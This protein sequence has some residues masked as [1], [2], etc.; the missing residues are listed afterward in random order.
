M[1]ELSQI[2]WSR[3]TLFYGI[4]NPGRQDDGLGPALISLL[5][6]Q[7]PS[8]IKLESNYQLNIEDA[9]LMADFDLVIF[10]DA[11]H[12]G[13]SPYHLSILYP[14]ESLTFS[15]H[16]LSPANVLGLCQKLYQKKPATYMLGIPGVA[17]NIADS[18]SPDASINL[19]ETYKALT[20]ALDPLKTW[21]AICTKSL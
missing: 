10:I 3:K 11:A 20:Q 9:L 7:I 8:W 16:A 18:L 1:V 5:E 4:G 14:E 6:N 12:S 21:N 17:W 2:P 19:H 13:S 15:T